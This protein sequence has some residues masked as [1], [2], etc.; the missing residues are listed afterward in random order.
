MSRVWDVSLQ[1]TLSVVPTESIEDTLLDL[2]PDLRDK[3]S[4]LLEIF[5]LG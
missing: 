4:R 1:V 2:M 3:Y 5:I